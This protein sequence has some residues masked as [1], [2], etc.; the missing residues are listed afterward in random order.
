[1]RRISG[2]MVA[3]KNRVCRV[4]GTSLQM[5]SM[6]GM[7]PMSSM[8]S[9][10]SMTRSSTPDIKQP[11][12]LEMIEQAA[13]GRDQHVDAAH[14]LGVLVVERNAADQ[15]GDVELMIDA[16]FDE[17]LLDLGRELAGRFDDERARHA[18]ARTALLELGQHRKDE[19]GGLSGAGLGDAEHVAPRQHMRNRLVLNGSG[20]SIA[21]GCDRSENLIG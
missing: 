15:E 10:S 21:G 6:S 1:M 11:P 7:K 20:A 19:G 12:A 17:A 3:V 8:R 2:G 9:A 18:G 4:N 13:G 5:R 14:Q 16:V